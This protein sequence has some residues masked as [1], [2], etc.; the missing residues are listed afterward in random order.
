MVDN[1]NSE[2]DT[3]TSAVRLPVKRFATR[4]TAQGRTRDDG[5]EG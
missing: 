4:S 2:A 3:T 5:P 1:D